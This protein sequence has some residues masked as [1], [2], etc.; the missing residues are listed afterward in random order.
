MGGPLMPNW[1]NAERRAA[2]LING[3]RWPAN[4]GVGVDVESSWAVAQVKEIASLSLAALTALAQQAQRDG[5]ERGKSGFVFVRHHKGRGRHAKPMLVVM[6]E[7]VFAAL[8][9]AS[10]Q[11]TPVEGG[12]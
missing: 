5:E 1:K 2:A 4:L 12:E 11:Q 7:D 3:I 8:H 6:T 9:Q 10:G